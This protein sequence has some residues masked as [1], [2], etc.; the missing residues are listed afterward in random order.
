MSI[1]KLREHRVFDIAIFDLV[2]SFIGII[3]IALLLKHR[4]WPQLKSMNFVIAAILI[5]LPL[6]IFSHMLFGVNTN[7]NYKLGLSDK[8]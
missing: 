6:S 1:A 5:T 7:L 3:I 4:F 8:P 2:S